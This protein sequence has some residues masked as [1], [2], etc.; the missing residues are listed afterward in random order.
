MK[1][2]KKIKRYSALVL[3]I[4]LFVQPLFL[5]FQLI[6]SQSYYEDQFSQEE[7]CITTINNRQEDYLLEKMAKGSDPISYITVTPDQLGGLNLKE[8]FRLVVEYAYETNT[9]Y[10]LSQGFINCCKALENDEPLLY[11]PDLAEALPFVIK[12]MTDPMMHAQLSRAARPDAP[13]SD[14]AIVGPLLGCD[15]NEVVQLL[16]KLLKTINECCAA[17]EFDF[18][19]VF[20]AI[21]SLIASAT[22]NVTATFSAVNANF[23]GTFTALN[24]LQNTLTTC[25]SELEFDFS[26]V[27]TALATLV[28][29][30]T[31]DFNSIFTFIGVNFEGTFTEL[32][33]IQNTLT[34][35]CLQ[36]AIDFSGI[37]T[38]LAHLVADA[39]CDFSEALTI[40]NNVANFQGTFTELD[41]IKNTLTTCCLQSSIDFSGIFT[42]LSHL[43]VTATCDFSVVVTAFNADFSGVFTALTDV[44]NS[45][46]ECCAQLQLDFDGTFSVIANLITSATCDLVEVFTLFVSFDGTFTELNDIQ[47]TLTTCCAQVQLD[48]DGTFSVLANLIASTTCD[49]VSV[50]TALNSSFEGTFTALNDIQA[51]LTTC[52]AELELDFAGTFSVLSHLVATTTCDFSSIFTALNDIKTT[53][54]NCCAELEFDFAGTFSSISNIVIIASCDFTPLFTVVDDI[55]NT[56]TTCCDNFNDTFTILN[57]IKNTLT[58]CCETSEFSFDG[59]FSV[60]AH[61]STPT[62]NLTSIFTAINSLNTTLT[63]CCAA[64]E[65]DFDG[66]FTTLAHLKAT[67]TDLTSIFTVLA[68]IKNTLTIC[69]A[70]TAQNFNG[71]FTMLANINTLTSNFIQSFTVLRQTFTVIDVL[72]AAICD[73]TVIR[74]SNFGVGGST[75]FIITNSGV[76]IFGE[77]ITFNPAAS[78]PAIIITTSAVTLDLQCFSLEQGNALAN[79]N[80]IQ[81]NSGLTDVTI[82]NGSVVNFTRAGITALASTRRINIQ[83][84]TCLLCGVRGIELLGTVG[85]LIQDAEINH[86]TING[87]CQG[88]SGDFAF[89]AQ[90]A[91]RCKLLNFNIK[92]C[93][94]VAHTLSAIRLDTCSQVEVTTVTIFNNTA[95]TLIGIQLLAPTRSS[96][97]NCIVRAN[98]ASADL[99]G[100]DISGAANTFNTFKEYKILNNTAGVN[101]IGVNL[102]ANTSANT[103]EN[104][105]IS[106][107]N[108][109]SASGFNLSGGGANNNRNIFKDNMVSANSATTG[110][111]IGFVV[112]GS[113][114]GI[115]MRSIISDNTSV[116]AQAIGISFPAP[117]GGN[118]WEFQEN[119][120]I[121][122]TGVNAASSFGF[123]V[124]VGVSNLF[125]LANFGFENGGVG[126]LPGNQL[127]GVSAGSSITPAAPATSNM[128]ALIEGFRNAAIAA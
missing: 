108:G 85:N 109:I 49:F 88:I 53:L 75:P 112:N 44:Q 20:T 82:K 80:G 113:D 101:F 106:W 6:A 96:L 34:E 72:T 70:Q 90:Q 81:I 127:N 68:D 24:D 48:F 26:G 73:P 61:F 38:A 107:N 30:S 39:T 32:N 43:E 56:L 77:D 119:Q 55:K 13:G 126:A 102:T 125:I 86:C 83:N 67:A 25:C 128:N 28:A 7:N 65:F 50:M 97:L 52:C 51:T 116:S 91:R 64:L 14:N 41:D 100:I 42:A 8:L 36:S 1:L 74:Q 21:S 40:F 2:G 35:C 59:T 122:N 99:T 15:L 84:I 29:S 120:I 89:V 31:C 46:T 105:N 10:Q 60:L 103:F 33:D 63:T 94:S 121:R 57:D 54:T 110:N 58:A 118:N 45:L 9:F 76:Y 98:N 23:S 95:T 16:N 17:L 11:V 18:S 111:C 92:N 123:S 114:N 93:G 22:C 87:C 79:V 115:I 19:G 78:T 12:A 124:L 4:I 47:N 69:C 5:Q 71:T 104:G 66:T 62:C 117:S 27:F 37:F 3:A